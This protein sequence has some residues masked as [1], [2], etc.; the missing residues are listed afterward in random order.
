MP[1]A[2]MRCAIDVIWIAL[3]RDFLRQVIVPGQW[4]APPTRAQTNR[5]CDLWGAPNLERLGEEGPA[6]EGKGLQRKSL[7]AHLML[8]HVIKSTYNMGAHH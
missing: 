6:G 7:K 2:I 8:V 4:S 3:P 1:V 5:R